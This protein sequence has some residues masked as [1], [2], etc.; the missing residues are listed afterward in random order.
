LVL[1][2]PYSLYGYGCG[3]ELKIADAMVQTGGE[4]NRNMYECTFQGSINTIELQLLTWV[5][6][7]CCAYS[8]G[9]SPYL[10]G[11]ML[12]WHRPV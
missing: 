5:N 8:Y 2:R 1:E 6:G 12:I 11:K 3:S 10:V 4:G 9:G 7:V